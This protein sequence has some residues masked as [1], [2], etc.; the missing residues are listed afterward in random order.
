[1]DQYGVPTFT[2]M[3]S[4]YLLHWHWLINSLRF[5]A[6]VLES[7]PVLVDLHGTTYK[8][9]ILPTTLPTLSTVEGDNEVKKPVE[10]TLVA[11]FERS[12]KYIYTGTSRGSFNV[13]DAETLE[14]LSIH[15]LRLNRVVDQVLS[16]LHCSNQAH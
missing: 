12:G 9:H 11:V 8:R 10:Y 6:S 1:M 7:D 13:I 16:S 4:I 15:H 14:V 3:T 2:L 5:A